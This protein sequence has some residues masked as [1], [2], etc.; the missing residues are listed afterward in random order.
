MHYFV[1]LMPLIPSRMSSMSVTHKQIFKRYRHRVSIAY[2]RCHHHVLDNPILSTV[3]Y[4]A[5][6]LPSVLAAIEPRLAQMMPIVGCSP[7]SHPQD[8]PEPFHWEPH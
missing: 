1:P 6:L 4:R 5:S 2:S 8:W 7:N 3:Q